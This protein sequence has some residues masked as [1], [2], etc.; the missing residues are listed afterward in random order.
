[1]RTLWTLALVALLTLALSGCT[2]SQP[3]EALDATEE[4]GA[5]PQEDGLPGAHAHNV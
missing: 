1:M 2:E 4:P 5:A 3:A